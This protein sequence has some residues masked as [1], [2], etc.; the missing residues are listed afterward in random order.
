MIHQDLSPAQMADL[1]SVCFVNPRPWSAAEFA[2][3]LENPHCFAL[4]HPLGFLLGRALAGEA[5]ILT[6]AVDP[7]ARR[8]GIARALVLSFFDAAR[9]RSAENAFLDVAADNA[10]AIALYVSCGFAQTGLRRR[11]YHSTGGA[12]VDAILMACPLLSQQE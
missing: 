10:A 9:S 12:A 4:F 7:S 1:H 8:K 5:E 11:Y 6:L 2:A 3:L